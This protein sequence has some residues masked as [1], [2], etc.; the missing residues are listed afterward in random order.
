[1]E[2]SDLT[3]LI[4]TMQELKSQLAT[5]QDKQA[6]LRED[7]RKT[8]YQE[9]ND[10]KKDINDINLDYRGHKSKANGYTGTFDMLRRDTEKNRDCIINIKKTLSIVEDRVNTLLD[11]KADHKTEHK[12]L[13]N[14]AWQIVIPVIVSLITSFIFKLLG[15]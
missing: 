3:N 8:F 7:C 14:R 11:Y 1:M 9:I 4:N 10:V 6:T 5:F 12:E 15:G 2:Y 13:N